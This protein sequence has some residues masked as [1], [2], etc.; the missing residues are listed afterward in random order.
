MTTGRINQVT[1]VHVCE[2]LITNE[3]QI[4][5]IE[6]CMLI[7]RETKHNRYETTVQLVFNQVF[8]Y[9]IDRLTEFLFNCELSLPK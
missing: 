6:V 5:H 2:V 9:F 8:E 1:V 4:T 7:R 3:K